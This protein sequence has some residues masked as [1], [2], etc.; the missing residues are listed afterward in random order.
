MVTKLLED[1]VAAEAAAASKVKSDAEARFEVERKEMKQ[2]EALLERQVMLLREELEALKAQHGSRT[3][4]PQPQSASSLV[5]ATLREA[6]ASK[7]VQLPLSPLA[8]PSR[9][10]R[11][12]AEPPAKAPA[13]P[14]V[15]SEPSTVHASWPTL[16]RGNDDIAAMAFLHET[17]TARGCACACTRPLPPLLTLVFPDLPGQC[18]NPLSPLRLVPRIR[19][20]AQILLR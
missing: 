19:V 17:L 1:A 9:P 6:T 18:A 2:N 13:V 12:V 10:A 3:S 14:S 16:S 8:L 11:P 4:T 20:S 15:K 5:A 7:A